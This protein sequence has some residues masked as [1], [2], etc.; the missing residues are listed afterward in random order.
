M[1]ISIN[2]KQKS[3]RG[4]INAI[5]NESQRLLVSMKR[6]IIFGTI[7]SHSPTKAQEEQAGGEA[8]L[9]L[10]N[11]RSNASTIKTLPVGR[12]LID[13]LIPHYRLFGTNGMIN[14]IL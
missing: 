4:T 6:T 7:Q 1:Q 5:L 10:L 2:D 8:G 14:R 11:I 13:Y 12:H 9:S 3:K